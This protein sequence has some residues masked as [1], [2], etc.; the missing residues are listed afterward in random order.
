M[1]QFFEKLSPF[2]QISG[3]ILLIFGGA[4]LF[5]GRSFL[6]K[7]MN[8]HTM[9]EEMEKMM[10]DDGLIQSHRSYEIEAVSPLN[11]IKPNQPVTIVY[12]IKDDQGNTLKNF[13]V[14]H[15]KVMHFIMVRKDLQQF[16]HIHP[17]F[18]KTSGE[19]SVQVTFAADGD[20]RMF[21]DFTPL[22]GQMK[23]DGERLPVTL[24]QD[25]VVGNL[26]KYKPQSIGGTER[27]KIFNGYSIIMTASSEPLASQNDLEITFEIK[28]GGKPVTN[29]QEYLGALGHTV[30]LKEGNLRFIHAHPTQSANVTQNGKI[31][32][33]ITF[34]EA[35]NYK[36]FSQFQRE[37]MIITSDFVANVL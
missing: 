1:K 12:T 25:I 21:A 18:N 17:Q 8:Q 5:F 26:A 15:E 28:K 34:P 29:L 11:D 6:S 31:I 13:N 32:F 36:L 14:V 19:F 27:A 9:T 4:Y 7:P 16:Q 37:G 3:A 22:V 23:S 10:A 24:F 2:F 33:M 35:G 20:Y 30:I